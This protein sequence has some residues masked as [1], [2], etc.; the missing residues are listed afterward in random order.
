MISYVNTAPVV[1]SNE[2]P[3]KLGPNTV[4]G[5]SGLV[6]LYYSTVAYMCT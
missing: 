1:T 5:V 4:K 3:H 2:N 6:N